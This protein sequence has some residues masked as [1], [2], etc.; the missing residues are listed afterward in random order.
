MPSTAFS[1]QG[2][3]VTIGTTVS[4]ATVSA[5]SKANPAVVTATAHGLTGGEIVKFAAVVGMTQ[6]NGKLACVKVIDANSF[7][8]YGIDSTGYTT[9]TSGGTATAAPRTVGNLKTFNGFNGQRT[10]IDTTNLASPAMEFLSGLVD[11][12]TFTMNMQV[13]NAG[14]DEGQLGLRANLAAPGVLSTMVLTYPN[15]QTRTFSAYVTDFPEQGGVNAVVDS[16][17]NMQISGAVVRG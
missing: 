2:S 15:G 1:A 7:Y 3:T 4:A 16:T 9:Y 13:D 5:I 17:V 8:A 14:T 11:N 10:K 12:G 6:I